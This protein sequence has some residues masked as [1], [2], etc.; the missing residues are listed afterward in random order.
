MGPQWRRLILRFSGFI[1]VYTGQNSRSSPLQFFIKRIFRI[2]PVYWALT[3][4]FV[5]I[6]L[7]MPSILRSASFDI[8]KTISSL[9][10]VSGPFYESPVLYVGWTLEFEFLFYAFFA[11]SMFVK[12]LR[13]SQALLIL[14]VF[15]TPLLLPQIDKIMFEFAYGMI[16]AILVMAVRIPASISW[17]CLLIGIALMCATIGNTDVAKAGRAFYWG[18][19]SALIIAGAKNIRQIQNKV[20]LY[21]GDASYSIYLVQVFTIPIIFKILDKILPARFGEMGILICI[22]ATIIAGAISYQLIER[23]SYKWLLNKL[24]KA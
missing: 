20:L 9:F 14:A 4:L 13:L 16:V 8:G 3:F 5:A 10:F 17:A 23:T 21:I 2:V 12:N 15:S 11:L 22:L 7:L 24:P 1:M 19:P 18:L 6:L